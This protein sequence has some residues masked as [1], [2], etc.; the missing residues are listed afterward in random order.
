MLV[1]VAVGV[2]EG[3][4]V[5]EG[6]GVLVVLGLG[7]QVGRG[8]TVGSGVTGGSG[9]GYGPLS[10]PSLRDTGSLKSSGLEALED[11]PLPGHSP[12]LVVL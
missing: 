11:G 3:V 2:C 12:S 1:S 6:V 5:C 9:G 8:V 10:V 4:S 7:G